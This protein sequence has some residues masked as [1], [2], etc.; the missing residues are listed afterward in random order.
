[1][2][3]TIPLA[4]IVG[5][6]LDHAVCCFN[7]FQAMEYTI[8]TGHG[9]SIFSYTL[10]EEHRLQGSFQGGSQSPI[11]YTESSDITLEATKED[12]YPILTKH[13]SGNPAWEAKRYGD[14]LMYDQSN[15]E[16][17]AGDNASTPDEPIIISR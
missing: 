17:C 2:S 13:P 6:V 14:Q 5:E 4:H 8:S 12:G 16:V 3:L 7:I 1:M 10:T 15:G 9:I 11:I